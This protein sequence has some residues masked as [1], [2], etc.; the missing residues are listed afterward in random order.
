V[1]RFE[2]E[3]DL[4]RVIER[5]GTRSGALVAWVENKS[6]GTPGFP[7]SILMKAGQSL[8]LELKVG[9]W[10]AGELIVEARNAQRICLR[11]MARAGIEALVVVGEIGS[12]RVWVGGPRSLVPVPGSGSRGQLEKVLLSGPHYVR[13]AVLWDINGLGIETLFGKF[14]QKE[15]VNGRRSRK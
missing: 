10:R 5:L 12:T 13:E 6:G 2:T 3:D 9:S 15:S 4:R 1:K 8:Y 11:K 7:D 14:S